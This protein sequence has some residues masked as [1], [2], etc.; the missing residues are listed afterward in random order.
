[1]TINGEG[2]EEV[3]HLLS[4]VARVDM[5][6]WNKDYDIDYTQ[7]A[8]AQRQNPTPAEKLMW[9]RLRNRRLGGFKFRRQH[10][11]RGRIA[12][13]FCREAQLIVEI[14]GSVHSQQEQR[15]KDVDRDIEFRIVGYS[16]VRLSNDEVLNQTEAACQKVLDAVYDSLHK[17]LDDSSQQPFP[18]LEMERDAPKGQGEV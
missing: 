1:M 12:D 2:G 15:V 3:S 4:M 17:Q 13:F 18:L 9:E 5:S 14:D 11:V 6:R 10:V 16:V 8:K 7:L